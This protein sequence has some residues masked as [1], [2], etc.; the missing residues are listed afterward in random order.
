MFLCSLQEWESRYWKV[1]EAY[2]S[3]LL[4]FTNEAKEGE[5]SDCALKS[6]S[7]PEQKKDESTPVVY[8]ARFVSPLLSPLLGRVWFAD[9]TSVRVDM[10]IEH[11][12]MLVDAMFAP[13][14]RNA[15]DVMLDVH[16]PAKDNTLSI[17]T[18]KP[19]N[20]CSACSRPFFGANDS[21]RL[22]V[23]VATGYCNLQLCTDCNNPQHRTELQAWVQDFDR[24]RRIMDKNEI[25]FSPFRA[26]MRSIV[27]AMCIQYTTVH[28]PNGSQLTTVLLKLVRNWLCSVFQ[29]QNAHLMKNS[30]VRA[31]TEGDAISTDK[32]MTRVIVSTPALLDLCFVNRHYASVYLKEQKAGCT[33]VFETL[34]ITSKFGNADRRAL[35]KADVHAADVFDFYVKVL[36]GELRGVLMDAPCDTAILK[37]E[38]AA[39]VRDC[40]RR[41]EQQ[42][43]FAH[44]DNEGTTPKTFLNTCKMYIDSE[45]NMLQTDAKERKWRESCICMFVPAVVYVSGIVKCF[46]KWA[47][48]ASPEEVDNIRKELSAETLAEE[49]RKLMAVRLARALD[50]NCKNV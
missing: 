24:A 5:Q 21:H 44:E 33:R 15:L 27:R 28:Q 18:D 26:F 43:I 6:P 9:F 22:C 41:I 38:E 46:P 8:K 1:R 29:R 47:Q 7:T 35:S 11:V 4:D 3:L 32:L 12:C 37:A 2:K 16:T 48:V 45:F 49:L 50:N 20:L 39:Q 31:A 14:L 17:F 25:A 36:S 30:I 40:L 34:R 23:R 42:L 19:N 13:T 10:C